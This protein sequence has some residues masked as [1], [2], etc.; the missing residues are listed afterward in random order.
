V[1]VK[2]AVDAP[3]PAVITDALLAVGVVE[4]VSFAPDVDPVDMM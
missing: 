3:L 1:L 2:G 4:G